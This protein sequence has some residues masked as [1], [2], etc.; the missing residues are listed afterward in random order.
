MNR[1]HH[2]IGSEAGQERPPAYMR[3]GRVRRT[4]RR[5]RR[6]MFYALALSLLLVLIGLALRGVIP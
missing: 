6:P 2:I 4:A 3:R 5:P 1:R